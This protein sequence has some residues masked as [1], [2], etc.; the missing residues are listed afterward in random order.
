MVENNN[1]TRNEI[2]NRL[3]VSVATIRKWQS[4]FSE[5]IKTPSGIRGQGQKLHYLADDVLLFSVISKLRKDGLTYVD[6][7]KR[8]DTELLTAT[9]ELIPE[10]PTEE[11]ESARVELALYMD[12]VRALEATEGELTATAKER[13]RLIEDNKELQERLIESERKAAKAEGALEEVRKQKRGFWQRF[14]G[15]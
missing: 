8:L 7:K 13:D 2:S 12:T 5:W 3:G 1:L 6:I 11:P 14:R 15:E 10:E 4:E 9:E